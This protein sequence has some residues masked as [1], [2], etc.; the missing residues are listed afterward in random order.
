[1][2]FNWGISNNIINC[3]FII[4]FPTNSYIHFVFQKISSSYMNADGI[5]FRKHLLENSFIDIVQRLLELKFL[6]Y[7]FFYTVKIFMVLPVSIKEMFVFFED[8][9]I[10]VKRTFFFINISKPMEYF[11]IDSV[12]QTLYMIELVFS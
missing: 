6:K 7:G 2:W 8:F 3:L 11:K 5:T 12:W 4:I 9:G 1:M 10:I